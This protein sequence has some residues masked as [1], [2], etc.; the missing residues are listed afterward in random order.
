VGGP[1]HRVFVP[2]RNS[3]KYCGTRRFITVFTRAFHW[4]LS[5][6]RSIQPIPSFLFFQRSILML[7]SHLCLYSESETV[8][9]SVL[10][11]K[12]GESTR[13]RVCQIK[14]QCRLLIH[15]L[16]LLHWVKIYE[17]PPARQ[18]KSV[19]LLPRLRGFRDV[20]LYR[21]FIQLFSVNKN[22]TEKRKIVVG[23]E[24]GPLS[25]VSTTEELLDR[26]VAAPV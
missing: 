16:S 10:R 4:S 22:K 17:A 12:C 5:W 23:L 26:K 25:L 20:T 8:C 15:C 1:P 3:P 11:W 9:V 2:L 6:A 19:K 14:F 21:G 7:S 18:S 13:S 24:R